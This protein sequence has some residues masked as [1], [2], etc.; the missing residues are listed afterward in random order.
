MLIHFVSLSR[1]NHKVTRCFTEKIAAKHLGSPSTRSGEEPA[2]TDGG[3]SERLGL[4]FIATQ[5]SKISL[6]PLS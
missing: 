3:A 4:S 2:Q 6:R 1:I 5:K